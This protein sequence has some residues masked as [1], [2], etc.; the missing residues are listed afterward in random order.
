MLMKLASVA[1]RRIDKFEDQGISNIAWALVTLGLAGGEPA[2]APGQLFVETA[3]EF[4]ST[5]LWGYSTQAVANLLWACVRLDAA[6]LKKIR[7]RAVRFCSAAAEVVTQ[8][9][10]DQGVSG[11]VTWK[12]LSGVAAALSYSKQKSQPVMRFVT[13]LAHRTAQQVSEGSLTAQQ[14]LNIA[15]SVARM[16]V[17]PH[18][19][20]AL[21]DSI[22]ACIAM[23]GDRLNQL[24]MYQWEQV[25]QW[26]PPGP[27]ARGPL[28]LG[29]A[30]RVP[31]APAQALSVGAGTSSWPLSGKGRQGGRAGKCV[32]LS[33]MLAR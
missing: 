32:S 22:A 17:P 25:R 12:D 3:M 33:G 20:Q 21:V 28:Q 1:T 11:A 5:E 4:C 6:R 19:M 7:Q 26:C 2:T 8:R 27:G 13:L 31:A 29:L 24:D 30:Y 14:M 9:M 10:L 15:L 23:R 16:R 18:D